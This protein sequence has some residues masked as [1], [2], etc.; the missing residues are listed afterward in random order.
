MISRFFIDRPIF[1]SVLSIVITLAGG[2][3]FFT[4]PVAQYPL[5]APPT[6]QV[7]CTY[8][9]ASAQVVSESVATPIEQ[10]VN[11]VENMLYMS[12]Q[13]TNDGAY[14]LTVTFRQGVDLNLAQVLVQNRVSLALPLLPDVIKQTGVNTRKKSPDMLMSIAINSPGGVYDQFYLSNYV[15]LRM[16]EEIARVPGVSDITMLGQRDYS[17]RI[18]V[19]PDMLA[20]RSLTAGDVVKAIQEQ[21]ISV[22]TGQIGQAPVPKGQMLQIPLSTLGRLVT[23]EQFQAI[24]IKSTADGR[25]T[26]LKDVARVELGPK[27]QD[28]NCQVNGKPSISITLFLLPDANALET[29]DLVRA[30]LDELSAD[31]PA[32][33]AYEIRYDTTPFIRE[34]IKNVYKTLE[35]A[36]LLVSVVVLLFLQ[37]WRSALIPLV[38]VPVAI[39]GTFAVMAL[40]GFSLN[41]L[42]LF[43]LVLA[44]GIVVDDAIV[45]VEAVEHHIEHGLSPRAA[46]LRAMDEVSGP[47]IAIG[48]VLSAVFVPCAFISG[49]IG[50]FF[51]Q[52]ALTIAASTLISAFNSLTL[53][54][55]LAAMLLRP[56]TAARRRSVLP[57]PFLAIAGGAAGYAWLQPYLLRYHIT[58]SAVPY[59]AAALG[60]VAVWLVSGLFNRLLS[61]FFSL[62]N[63]A[64]NFSTQIYTRFVG[65]LLWISPVV[66][67]AYAGLVYLTYWEFTKTPKGFIPTQDMGYAMGNVQLPDAAS[68]ERAW[69][70]LKRLEKIAKETPGVQHTQI[71]SGQSF[72]LSATGSNFGSMIINFAPFEDRPNPFINRFF[73][74]LDRPVTEAK[75]RKWL[76]Q[77]KTPSLN[78]ETIIADLR[79]RFIAG[80]PG[81]ITAVLGPAPVRGVGRAGGFKLMVEDRGELGSRTLQEQTEN[82]AQVAGRQPTLAGMASVFRASVPQLYVDVNRTECLRKEVAIA[83]LFD[84]LRVFLGSRYVNDFNWMGRTWQVIVQADSRFRNRPEEIHRIRVRNARGTMVPLGSLVNIKEQTGPLVLTRYNMHPAAPL[85]GTAAPG[86]SSGTAIDVMEKLARSEL[87]DSMSIEWT[88]LAFLELQAG[89]TA[90]IVFGFAVVMVFLVLAAQYESWALPLAIIMVVPMCLLGALTGVIITGSEINIFTQ[91]GFVVLVGLASKNAIL[92]VEFAKIRREQGVSRRQATLDACKLRL[93]PI[94]MTSMAFI[95]GVV[96]LLLSD[97]AGAEMRRTLGTTVFSGMLGVTLFGV[98]LTPVFFFIIDW[99]G[100]SKLFTSRWARLIFGIPLELISLRSLR[101]RNGRSRPGLKIKPAPGL[102]RLPVIFESETE[103]TVEVA[104]LVEQK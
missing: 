19:D 31:F 57:R 30:K 48:L 64:F 47:V 10:Q 6:V 20:A 67:I 104:E 12:S 94:V 5:V 39:V 75:I 35:E 87:P 98:F 101:H 69:D 82:L 76:N 89:N 83:D 90:M 13:C 80:A 1:A 71:M 93:R 23:A 56:H 14:N 34:S 36:I 46:T 73:Q 72:L 97:G 54:P 63:K 59:V 86:T 78:S 60:L 7:D 25:V 37:N 66:V 26:R 40:F 8:P 44:I 45:V 52:F 51:R 99:A 29:G 102:A 77:P 2:I 65:S 28:I 85:N 74:W 21:N 88:E 11:G 9:G 38:A 91:V 4:L 79:K 16:K 49:I 33:V 81:A 27:N 84:S 58:A 32:G 100:E 95:L 3:A 55:A 24:I 96:P 41:N 17:M 22:S 62:F 103:A 43:G 18:W 15:L 50:Q 68:A 92:I 70:V 42:T 53:S 61:G